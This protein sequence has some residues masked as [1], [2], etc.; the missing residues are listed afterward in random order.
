[1][2]VPITFPSMLNLHPSISTEMSISS[3]EPGSGFVAS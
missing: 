1:V 2:L 3:P